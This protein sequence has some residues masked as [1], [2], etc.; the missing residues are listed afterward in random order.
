MF[1]FLSNIKTLFVII[2]VGVLMAAAAVPGLDILA[3]SEG[4]AAGEERPCYDQGTT[5]KVKVA[6][7]ESGPNAFAAC[8]NNKNESTRGELGVQTDLCETET[9]SY[10]VVGN[11]G[12]FV[13][14][15]T[16]TCQDV[17][18]QPEPE[19]EPEPIPELPEVTVS[20]QFINA[21]TKEPLSG[22]RIW[23]PA[24]GIGSALDESNAAGEFSFVSDTTQVTQSNTLYTSYATGC[25]FQNWGFTSFNRN[26]DDSLRLKA[27]LFDFVPGDLLIN[28]LM[29]AD[30]ELG[31][32]P[33]WPATTLVV[34]S[35][36]PVKVSVAYPEEDKVLG[37][38]QLQTVHK[39]WNA[40]PL[41][42]PTSVR[43][44]DESG[45]VYNSP[46]MTLPIGNGCSA[47]SLTFANG[48]FSW[49]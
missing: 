25:Y 19:P 27:I 44:I 36:V 10:C 15:F 24:V 13:R 9:V 33:L 11:S 20:G 6:K 37:N 39:I 47:A 16:G 31:T 3:T 32:V 34:S 45:A 12:N 28:P 35:D 42:H 18:P 8:I 46:E 40:M 29:T 41:E 4:C 21:V 14:E 22:V 1:G 7:G 2:P 38:S 43:L 48:E 49:E 17:T 5:N 23:D 30:V 26:P